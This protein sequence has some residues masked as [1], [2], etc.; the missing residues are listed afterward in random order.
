MIDFTSYF[1][2]KTSIVISNSKLNPA[3]LVTFSSGSDFVDR[4]IKPKT[5]LKDL[6]TTNGEWYMFSKGNAHPI[7]SEFYSE[8]LDDVILEAENSSDSDAIMYVDEL[9]IPTTP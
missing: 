3:A 5:Y 8:Y 2:P 4:F 6:Y 1:V 9:A 7:N